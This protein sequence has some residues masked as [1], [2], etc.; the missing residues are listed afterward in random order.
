MTKEFSKAEWIALEY[1]SFRL[2]EIL[3]IVSS[4]FE[5]FLIT[6]KNFFFF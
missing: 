4:S 5:T 3:I 6:D 2:P 1:L